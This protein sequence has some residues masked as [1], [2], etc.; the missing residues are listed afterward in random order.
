MSSTDNLV[1]KERRALSPAVVS[2]IIIGQLWP[3]ILHL[4]ELNQLPTLEKLK[5]HMYKNYRM[6]SNDC[7][8]HVNNA[9]KDRLLVESHVSD[10]S[11]EE[12][13]VY[14][15]P[16]S[17]GFVDDHDWYCFDCHKPG[18]VVE[19]GRCWRVYHSY[20]LKQEFNELD[21]PFVCDVCLDLSKEYDTR[22]GE[23]VIPVPQ[24]NQ[25]LNYA[26][27]QII[28]KNKKLVELAMNIEDDMKTKQLVFSKTDLTQLLDK[29]ESNSYKKLIEFQMDVQDLIHCVTLLY[30]TIS[31]TAATTAQALDDCLKEMTEIRECVDCY[32]AETNQKADKNWFC[33]P[34]NPPHDLVYAKQKGYPFWPSKVIT[35]DEK[36]NKCYVRFFG[37]FHERESIDNKNIKPIGSTLQEL[38]ISK[39]SPPLAAALKELK[40]YQNNLQVLTGSVGDTSQ[41]SV[42]SLKNLSAKRPRKRA[43]GTRPRKRSNQME[44]KTESIDENETTTD[45]QIMNDTTD[46]PQSPVNTRPKQQFTSTPKPFV[47]SP[48]RTRNRGMKTPFQTRI[49]E[50]EKKTIPLKTGR[51]SLQTNKSPIKPKRAH[52]NKYF[53]NESEIISDFGNDSLASGSGAKKVVNTKTNNRLLNGIIP[54]MNETENF[55]DSSQDSQVIGAKR[56]KTNEHNEQNSSLARSRP[57]RKSKPNIRYK[58]PEMEV[59]IPKK[60]QKVERIV[61][62]KEVNDNNVFDYESMDD[63]NPGGICFTNIRDT[64]HMMQTKNKKQ[65]QKVTKNIKSFTSQLTNGVLNPIPNASPVVSPKRGRPKGV[66]NKATIERMRLEEL[67]AMTVS[68]PPPILIPQEMPIHIESKNNKT[69]KKDSIEMQQKEEIKQLKKDLEVVK[70][71]NYRLQNE[72]RKLSAESQE[73]QEIN[74]LKEKHLQEMSLMKKKQWCFNCEAEAIYFCCWNTSYCSTQCQQQ[75]WL[76]GHKKSCRR[77]SKR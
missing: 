59:K 58:S 64:K 5:A 19:C 74:E 37:S 72:V 62:K 11:G 32:S 41:P 77:A 56:L 6:T 24:L 33:N 4:K 49:T 65:K 23:K 7:E 1:V 63:S 29:T 9:I 10:K 35:R 42:K 15:P 45:S 47:K 27:N 8:K 67:K 16:E 22:S 3:T 21:K 68:S 73:K 39:P 17:D 38:R 69:P 18:S 34:C 57:F 31:T 12:L 28:A 70:Q 13:T 14:S 48:I 40:T 71:L 26:F 2:E 36:K 43:D 55:S 30:G 50:S 44:I 61:V 76:S 25:I 53:N 51:R 54:Q 20:C 66:K 46:A 60:K 75:H 52:M